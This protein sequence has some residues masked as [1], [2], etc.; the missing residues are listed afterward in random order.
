[1]IPRAKPAQ[2]A[3]PVTTALIQ[4]MM[5]RREASS[6]GEAGDT[7]LIQS[8]MPR[9][10]PAQAAKPVTTA[11]IQSMMPRREASS[12]GEAG[13]GGRDVPVILI[14]AKRCPKRAGRQKAPYQDQRRPGPH[15]S[16]RRCEAISIGGFIAIPNRA[17][18]AVTDPG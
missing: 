14:L 3:K 16:G 4:S 12:G 13:D 5:P 8:M 10:K 18:Q 9:A 11:L 1:M 7:A 17:S 2:A 15:T 6:G